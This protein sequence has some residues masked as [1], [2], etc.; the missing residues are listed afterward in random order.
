[1]AVA[2][3]FWPRRQSEAQKPPTLVWAR[4]AARLLR[5]RALQLQQGRCLRESFLIESNVALFDCLTTSALRRK[6]ADEAG[7][8][9][10]LAQD[11]GGE[12]SADWL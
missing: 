1:M 10:G 5:S 2:S 11:I 6:I 4:V 9:I 8:G 12:P 3:H 7:A